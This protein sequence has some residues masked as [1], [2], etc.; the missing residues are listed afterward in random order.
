MFKRL[1]LKALP[2]FCLLILTLG[3]FPASASASLV[4]QYAYTIFTTGVPFTQVFEVAKFDPNLG[5]LVGITMTL[6]TSG[7]ATV[8]VLNI[9]LQNQ[10]FSNAWARLPLMVTGP[11]GSL[12][13]VVTEAGPASG[14]ISAAP[15]AGGMTTISLPGPPRT[16]S[17]SAS[18]PAANFAS[19]IGSGGSTMSFTA[20]ATGDYS[21]TSDSGA[22]WFSGS[23]QVGGTFTIAYEYIRAEVPEPVSMALFGS[24]LLVMGLFGRK[25]FLR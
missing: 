7:S 11:D 16:G 14:T 4:D 13:E 5:T 21:G 22:L 6:E 19:Y 17:S 3:L 15:F 10:A 2:G 12:V 1:M 20:A 18:V 23:G 8:N 25:R 9:T 24:G